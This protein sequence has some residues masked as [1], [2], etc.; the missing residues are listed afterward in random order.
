MYQEI[1]YVTYHLFKIMIV[2]SSQFIQLIKV[3]QSNSLGIMEKLWLN[4]PIYF[5]NS[6]KIPQYHFIR[7][8]PFDSEGGWQS[9]WNRKIYF[10]SLCGQIIYFINIIWTIKCFSCPSESFKIYE[11]VTVL[12]FHQKYMIG[13]TSKIYNI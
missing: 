2:F 7:G 9:F 12:I 13:S 3:F 4:Y 5:K 6:E 1:P 10:R 11:W 8:R